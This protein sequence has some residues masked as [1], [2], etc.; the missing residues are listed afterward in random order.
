MSANGGPPRRL[1]AGPGI[2][3]WSFWSQDGQSIYFRSNRSGRAEI[4]KMPAAGGEAVQITRNGGDL[5]QE[6]PD[7]RFLYY[8]KGDPYPQQCSIWRIP[9]GGGEETRMLDSIHCDGF[10]AVREEGIYYLAKPDEKHLTELCLHE[11][12]TGKTKGILMVPRWAGQGLAVSPDGRTILYTAQT[13]ESGSELM[14][15]EDFR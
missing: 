13:D 3:I 5:P 1:T 7:G 6:S 8:M 10:W 15:V 9:T 11:F 12:A 14:L 4:W 2:D